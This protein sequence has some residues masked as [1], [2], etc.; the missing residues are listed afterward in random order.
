MGSN[1]CELFLPSLIRKWIVQLNFGNPPFVKIIPIFITSKS[2][3][4]RTL[5]ERRHLTLRVVFGIF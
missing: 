3:L 1:F 4:T 5:E 2:L